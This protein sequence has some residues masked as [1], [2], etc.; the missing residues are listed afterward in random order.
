MTNAIM[1]NSYSIDVIVTDDNSCANGS[2]LSAT[3]T[4]TLTI[5]E[6]NEAP[7]F[8]PTLSATYSSQLGGSTDLVM[9]STDPNGADSITY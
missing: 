7:Y 8:S 5:N 4:Y 1:G 9:T 2:V 3:F 6:G